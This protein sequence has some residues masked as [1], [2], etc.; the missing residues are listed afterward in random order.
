M[1][2]TAETAGQQIPV[3]EAVEE[4]WFDSFEAAEYAPDL[5][6][7][8]TVA[9]GVSAFGDLT[10]E[11]VE[12]F[13]EQGYL[14]VHHA[15]S[16]AEVHAAME[17]LLDLIDGKNPAFKG[18][19]FEAKARPILHT[20]PRAQKQGYVRKLQGYVDHEPRLRAIAEHPQLLAIMTR[21]IGEPPAL[22]ANQ[23][24]VKP[25]LVGREKP[26]H[27][28]HAFFNLPL[29][30]RVVGAWIA[31]DEALPENGCMHVIPGTH[32]EGPVPHFRRRDWQ[33]CDSDVATTRIV[34][35]PLRPGG[36][37]LFDGLLHHG[38]P[39]SRSERWRR[40][41][42]LHYIPASVGRTTTEERLAL[43]GGE[44]RGLT[45]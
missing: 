27:Q 28:D 30:T 39:A 12:R 19:Q 38:T 22:F 31:L 6:Q 18:I 32:R 11:H 14:V 35:V 20:L 45:C 5:Y 44:A 1:A 10:D 3:A 36:C 21:L 40:A 24:M 34:A 4:A 37:L 7:Y 2:S 17:G 33:I 9:D 16:A 23:A 43:F 29:G 41:L 42:Q 26:W 15:F 13:R 8:A 25:P